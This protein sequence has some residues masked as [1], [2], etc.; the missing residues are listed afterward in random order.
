MAS[1]IQKFKQALSHR[2]ESPTPQ[3]WKKELDRWDSKAKALRKEAKERSIVD[4]EKIGK[5]TLR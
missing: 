4:W 2:S 3:V 1:K 5:V